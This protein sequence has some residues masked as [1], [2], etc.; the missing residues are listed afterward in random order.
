MRTAFLTAAL[1]LAAPVHAQTV[2]AAD[3][4][5]VV[6]ALQ[7]L[8]Y[9]AQLEKDDTGD[10]LIRTTIS[11]LNNSIYFY[12]C[13]NGADCMELQ[14]FVWMDLND[15]VSLEKVNDWNDRKVAGSAAVDPQ[16]D[17]RLRFFVVTEGG[18]PMADF[19]R[20]AFRWEQ[21]LDEFK[22]HVGW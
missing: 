14:F 7:T 4:Q 3:P 18:L 15:P 16:G 12:G 1:F 21:A 9:R 17:V 20:V 11:G 8:G 2:D 5:S 13:V 22:N 6:N 10:P 19:E